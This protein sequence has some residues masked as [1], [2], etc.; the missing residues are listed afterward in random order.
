MTTRDTSLEVAVTDALKKMIYEHDLIKRVNQA[1][2]RGGVPYRLASRDMLAKMGETFDG[3]DGDEKYFMLDGSNFVN[4]VADAQ[5]EGMVKGLAEENGI[6]VSADHYVV[7]T[8][9]E[10]FRFTDTRESATV[11]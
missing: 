4:P 6:I 7:T 3:Y 1:M 2:T 5:I 11:N 10:G 8:T 9:S